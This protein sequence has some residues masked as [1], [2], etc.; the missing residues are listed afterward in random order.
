MIG[1]WGALSIVTSPFPDIH[2]TL[3]ET[4][5]LGLDAE[6]ATPAAKIAG[7]TTFELTAD[8]AALATKSSSLWI[9]GGTMTDPVMDKTFPGQFGFGALR[10]AIDN[11]NG[12][13]V[14]WIQFPA[15]TKHVFC[16]AYYVR[17]PPTSGTII[18]RKALV[19]GATQTKTF[20]FVG[21][22]SYNPGGTF[23]LSVNG[24]SAGRDDVL[25]RRDERRQPV[26]GAGDRA[27]RMDAGRPAMHG[28]QPRDDRQGDGQGLDRAPGRRHGDVH[29]HRS[30]DPA[31]GQAPPQQD[32]AGRGRD[33]RIR[34]PA[35]GSDTIVAA[36]KG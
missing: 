2:T 7:A 23:D 36:G 10:C 27:E 21:N 34:R 4:E 28:R 11:L 26:D 24:G 25:P 17:P 20:G 33:V 8:E 35:P 12:D 13:N 9:Q 14:E 16:Y 6:P 29:V 30:A 5:L 22:V 15:G 3:A 1:K 18:I 31:A 19:A 32:H